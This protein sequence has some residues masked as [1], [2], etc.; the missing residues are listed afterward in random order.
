MIHLDEWTTLDMDH[1]N[2]LLGVT[3][4]LKATTLR[5]PVIGGARVCTLQ[6]FR[7]HCPAIFMD[8]VCLTIINVLNFVLCLQADVLKLKEAL[9]SAV[10]VMQSMTSSVC[11]LSIKVTKLCVM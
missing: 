4:A 3:A 5:L 9:S 2:S 7:S 1:L 8:F 10:D 6:F 11:P